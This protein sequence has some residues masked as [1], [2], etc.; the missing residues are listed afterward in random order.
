MMHMAVFGPERACQ[1]EP[2]KDAMMTG[3]IE[4]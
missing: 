4:V 1:E 3:K 2:Y